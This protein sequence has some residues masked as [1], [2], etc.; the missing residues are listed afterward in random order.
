MKR[1]RIDC[2]NTLLLYIVELSN[3]MNSRGVWFGIR[4]GGNGNGIGRLPF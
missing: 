4:D 2:I 3:E 1:M